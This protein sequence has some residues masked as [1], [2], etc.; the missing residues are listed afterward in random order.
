M[1]KASRNV[2]ILAPRDES[3]DSNCA[4]LAQATFDLVVRAFLPKAFSPALTD[5]L[6]L[7]EFAQTVR[8]HSSRGARMT[9]VREAEP[10]RSGSPGKAW[11]PE[12]VLDF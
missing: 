10:R 5:F 6:I 4:I 11:E 3:L 1:I 8:H 7:D 2:V 9:T 12:T